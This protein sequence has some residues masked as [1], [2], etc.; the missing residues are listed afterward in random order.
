MNRI[1]SLSSAI[2]WAK[3]IILGVC[4]LFLHTYFSKSNRHFELILN[5]FERKKIPQNLENDVGW[6]VDLITVPHCEIQNETVPSVVFLVKTARSNFEKKKH[7][8][9]IPPAAASTFEFN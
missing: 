9:E 6:D 8:K 5:H 2:F 1:K 7:T 4:C 3:A